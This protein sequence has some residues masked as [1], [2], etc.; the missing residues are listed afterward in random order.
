MALPMTPPSSPSRS[1]TPPGEDIGCESTTIG[2]PSAVQLWDCLRSPPPARK[3]RGLARKARLKN[4]DLAADIASLVSVMHPGGG[5]A[6]GCVVT[7]LENDQVCTDNHRPLD[8]RFIN[9]RHVPQ[10]S[11]LSPPLPHQAVASLLSLSGK[12][13]SIPAVSSIQNASTG[14]TDSACSVTVTTTGNSSPPGEGSSGEHVAMEM[15]SA[16]DSADV[17]VVSPMDVVVPV[18]PKGGV[19]ITGCNSNV[20][21]TTTDDD[22]L[23]SAMSATLGAGVSSAESANIITALTSTDFPNLVWLNSDLS[24]VDG[25]EGSQAGTGGGAGGERGRKE[26]VSSANGDGVEEMDTGRPGTVEL[27]SAV[28]NNAL[29]DSA[30]TTGLTTASTGLS[31]TA[32]VR[33][34]ASTCLST[35]AG[36]NTVA[37]STL[38]LSSCSSRDVP[39][40]D[41]AMSALATP[42][43]NPAHLVDCVTTPAL[44]TPPSTTNSLSSS[45]KPDDPVLTV[46]SIDSKLYLCSV[47]PNAPAT[48]TSILNNFFPNSSAV[49][50]YKIPKKAAT[51]SASKRSL[52]QA[53]RP[54]VTKGVGSR[55]GHA[56]SLRAGRSSDEA[57]AGSVC[58][59]RQ[60]KRLPTT[61]HQLCFS[62]TTDAGRKWEAHDIRGQ[63][64]LESGAWCTILRSHDVWP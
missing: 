27:E 20:T 41:V 37:S 16:A 31:G 4:A 44:T 11:L 59:K 45:S 2:E 47:P 62:I 36:T 23:K 52:Q 1:Q 55:H 57:V 42:P 48:D 33:T 8:V 53:P 10:N 46:V 43:T 56:S 51:F 60:G 18:A 5:V 58:L 17:G 35:S 40:I 38:S 25:E 54:G 12:D 14:D 6:K 50:S 39:G 49:Q 34:T 28:S 61:P 9:N 29:E 64:T 3:P 19:P 24:L 63:G 7:S 15:E 26:V 30:G 32:T 21:T 22:I 13:I